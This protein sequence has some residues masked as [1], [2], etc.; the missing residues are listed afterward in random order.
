MIRVAIFTDMMDRKA[1]ATAL[2]T[3][4]IAEAAL[5][6][7]N[8]RVSLVHSA[9]TGDPLYARAHEIILPRVR[10]PKFSKLFSE[11]LFLWRTRNDF[12]IIQY[13]QESIYPLFW[14]SHAKIV[15]TV[16]SHIE[17]W[18]DYAL[19]VRYWMVWTTLKFFHRR[20]AAIICPIDSVKQSVKRFSPRIPEKKFNIIPLG[21]EESFHRPP[22]KTLAQQRIKDTY[23]ISAPFILAPG[24]IDPQKNIPRVIEAYDRLRKSHNIPHTLVVGGKQNP[25]E[26][27]RV[28]RLIKDK[29]LEASVVFLPYIQDEDMPALYAAADVVV[30]PSL[31]EGIGLP[32]IEAMAVGAPLVASNVYAFPETTHGAALLVDPRDSDALAD[33]IWKLLNDTSLQLALREKGKERARDFS[34]DTMATQMQIVYKNV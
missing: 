5:Q 16:H 13:P 14:L 32:L 18:R 34:W 19:R 23:T 33:A 29:E 20:L 8:L 31:H 17:G 28:E 27:A 7:P 12:D 4:K 26:V 3:R 1:K 21:V 11:A 15:I 2:Y 9:A 30:Y 25:Q 24:R 6:N 10:L 22:E